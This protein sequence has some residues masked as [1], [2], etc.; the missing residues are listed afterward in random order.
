MIFSA[1]LRKPVILAFIIGALLLVIGAIPLLFGHANATTG[2][3][4]FL[5][6]FIFY[7]ALFAAMSVIP[8]QL[9]GPWMTT[10][11]SLGTLLFFVGGILGML[12]YGSAR[13]S[14][15]VWQT[16]SRRAISWRTVAIALTAFLLLAHQT[17][18]HL[19][20]LSYTGQ[21]FP[22][23][24]AYW[25]YSHF[26]FNGDGTHA[27]MGLTVPAVGWKYIESRPPWAQHFWSRHVAPTSFEDNGALITADEITNH[28]LHHFYVQNVRQT[29]NNGESPF[30]WNGDLLIVYPTS[31]LIK[32]YGYDF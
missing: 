26:S 4:G 31:G 28:S 2:P 25:S 9:G 8:F 16:F 13:L 32:L 18:G 10:P 19:I 22:G 7:T 21:M 17:M 30:M 27:V 24:V 6:G 11:L 20:Y 5:V 12:L 15:A 29:A 14:I 3:L 1:F 23:V